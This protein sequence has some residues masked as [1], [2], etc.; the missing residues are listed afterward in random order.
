MLNIKTILIMIKVKAFY[1]TVCVCLGFGVYWLTGQLLSMAIST[2]GLFALFYFAHIGPVSYVTKAKLGSL[3]ESGIVEDCGISPFQKR[4]ESINFEMQSWTEGMGVLDRFRK[5]YFSNHSANGIFFYCYDLPYLNLFLI[6][7]KDIQDMKPWNSS[8]KD[9]DED[10]MAESKL[11][12]L[13]DK[14]EIVLPVN[15]ETLRFWKLHEE[16]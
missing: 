9:S 10:Y 4:F 13:K 2:L 6:K 8:Y 11:I 3:I 7:W 5:L 15:N 14:N 12:V 1:V 16:L